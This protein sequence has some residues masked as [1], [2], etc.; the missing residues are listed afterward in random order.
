MSSETKFFSRYSLTPDASEGERRFEL[1]DTTSGRIGYVSGIV[2]ERLY[3]LFSLHSEGKLKSDQYNCHGLSRYLQGKT[4][5]PEYPD[6]IE[7][8]EFGNETT[9]DQ[10]TESLHFPIGVH[11]WPDRGVSE[12]GNILGPHSGTILG[13]REDGS[14]FAIQKFGPERL[15]ICDPDDIL[16][17][18]AGVQPNFFG[19]R[20][21]TLRNIKRALGLG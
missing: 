21:L 20:K 3:R 14:L 16:R 13:R 12:T 10:A 18:G 8:S 9:I 11:V 5:L 17:Y 4:K 2:G 1:S 7:K 15:E 6:F 19:K